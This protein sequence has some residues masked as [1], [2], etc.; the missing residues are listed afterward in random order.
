MAADL[1]DFHLWW[2]GP[3]WLQ[4]KAQYLVKLNDSRFGLF[5]SD[6]RIQGEVKTNCLT[7]L[8]VAAP[9]LLIYA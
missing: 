1:M 2:N 8:A 3:L 9:G 4:D 7:A 6:K 5:L